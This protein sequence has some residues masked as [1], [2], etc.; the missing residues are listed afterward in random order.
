[1]NDKTLAVKAAITAFFSGLGAFLGWKGVMFIVWFIAMALD[2]IS[3]SAAAAKNGEWS[4]TVARQ[5]LWHKGGMILVVVVAAIADALFT[6]FLPNI[7]LIAV[8]V[9]NPG[10]LFPLVLTWYIITEAGSVLENAVK[11]GAKVPG[12]LR[13]VLKLGEEAIDKAGD[14]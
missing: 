10:L 14:Q 1:M 5:G 7:P 3:G 6:F 12:W 2:Y 11:M 9:R 13:K 4:S 8:T